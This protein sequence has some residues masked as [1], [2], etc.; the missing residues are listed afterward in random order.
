MRAKISGS[1]LFSDIQTLD[2]RHSG[3][4]ISNIM[5]DSHQVQQLVSTGVLN[6]MK[7][8]LT[9]IVLVGLMFYQNMYA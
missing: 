9:L 3:K 6:L 2:S 1:I 4:Y 8:S 5:Y 7:D